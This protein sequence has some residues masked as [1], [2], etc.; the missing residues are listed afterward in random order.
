MIDTTINAK[1]AGK[2]DH[3]FLKSRAFS[4][5]RQPP[6]EPNARGSPVAFGGWYGDAQG[7]SGLFQRHPGEES[8]FDQLCLA[9]HLG[10]QDRQGLV[11]CQDSI[12]F[13]ARTRRGQ[14]LG[15]I[16]AKT[17]TTPA[18][19]F[20]SSRLVNQDAPHGLS[21]GGEEVS[22]AIPVLGLLYADQ[23]QVRL[24][25]QGGWLKRLARRFLSHFLR[26][27]LPQLLVDEGGLVGPATRWKSA[28]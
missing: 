24:V 14:G 23:P 22:P 10:C 8:Q 28:P 26:G 13:L 9:R 25:D 17:I 11:D 1:S 4:G 16:E 27:Q 12:R 7:R 6:I 3:Y 2:T 5:F 19:A 15:K 18:I 21:R 20:L